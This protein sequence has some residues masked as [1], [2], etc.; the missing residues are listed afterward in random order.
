MPPDVLPN[1]PLAAWRPRRARPLLLALA[2]LVSAFAAACQTA[3]PV[4]PTPAIDDFAGVRATA[5]AS[6]Q[7]G[8][9]ALEQGLLEEALVALDRANVNDPDRREDIQ[10][11]LAETIRRIQAL[12]P[13]PTR[14][15]IPTRTPAPAFRPSITN[16]P[17][18]DLTP[19]PMAQPSPPP[20]FTTW[21][22]PQG[23]FRI[24]VP[25]GWAVVSDPPAEFGNGLVAARS[26][27]GR[28]EIVLSVD[29]GTQVVSPEL[30]AAKM[31]LAMQDLPGYALETIVPG[32]TSGSPSLRRNFT[33]TQRTAD[34]QSVTARGFQVAVLRGKTPYVLTALAPSTAY[35]SFQSAFE[36]AA[37]SVAFP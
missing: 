14:T 8:R 26:P 30:Y 1:W 35:A 17:V 25:T 34:G 19:A 6:Y 29:T 36:Q 33:L 15:A 32:T 9:Q 2:L 23:R 13:T 7:S 24:D 20:G 4:E 10:A 31:E 12:P 18:P 27:D 28:A 5:E 21:S 16:S 11:A 3:P 37:A 22:D